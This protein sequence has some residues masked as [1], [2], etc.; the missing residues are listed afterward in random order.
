MAA[1]AKTK[2][3][4]ARLILSRFSAKPNKNPVFPPR[5]LSSLP[6][7]RPQITHFQKPISNS[8]RSPF[9]NRF[10]SS[11]SPIQEL[12][13]EVE[14]EKQ[15]EREE[16]K[17][18]GEVAEEDDEEEEDY[19]GVGPLIEKL[20]KKKLKDDENVEEFEEPTDSESDDDDE[21]FTEE[22]VKKRAEE[23]EKKFKRHEELLKNF[24]E[25]GN[26]SLS[27]SSLFFV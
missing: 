19:M 14:R 25:A 5:N 4:W 21:R 26:L 3:T 11:A 2:G 1:I 20:E 18:K 7:S 22:A 24:T 9:S 13:A 17:R 6:V 16:R 23:F 27:L 15:R 10:F 12:L 8:Q